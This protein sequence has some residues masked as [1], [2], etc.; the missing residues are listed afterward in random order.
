MSDSQWQAGLKRD[1]GFATTHWT[2]VFDAGAAESP[3]ATAALAELCGRYWYPLYAYVRQRGYQAAEAQDLTQDFFA[4]LLEKNTLAQA[5]PERGKFRTFLLASLRNFLANEWDRKIAEKRGGARRVMSLDLATG[6][7]RLLAE[8]AVAESPE[9]LFERQW[10]YTLLDAVTRRSRDEFEAVGKERQFEL[11]QP[12]LAAGGRGANYAE[13]GRQ[14]GL[15]DEAAR[16]AASRMRRRYREL[17][18]AEVGATVAHPEQVDDEIR[19]L[20][21]AVSP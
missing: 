15:S 4:R 1:R 6:E 2:L 7:S 13:I 17:L 5:A 20:F 16:Q 21:A 9:R 3:E 14:L 11:L 18:R 10:A 12:A 19:S 8:P